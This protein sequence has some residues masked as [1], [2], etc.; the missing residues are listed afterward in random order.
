MFIGFFLASTALVSS[1]LGGRSRSVFAVLAVPVLVL[2]IPIFDTTFVTLARKLAGR[3]ASQGGRDHTSH[4]L[5]AL[6]LSERHAVWMLYAFASMAGLLAILAVRQ[7]PADMSVA[8][9]A[10]FAITLALVGVYL[11]GVRVYAEE[12]IAAAKQK[13]MVSFL[14]DM[15]HKRRVF[16]VA[17]DVMLIV[18]AYYGAHV[19]ILGPI[20]NSAHWQVFLKTLPA[21]VFVQL[22]AFLMTGI[23]RG[24]WRYA[25]VGDVGVYARAVIFAVVAAILTVVFVFRIGTFSRGVFLVDA[26]VL[27]TLVTTSRFAFRLMR[28][29]VPAPHIRTGRRALIFGAGDGGELLHRELLNNPARNYVPV[30]FADDDQRK[31]GKLMHGLRV[32]GGSLADVCTA[33][34]VEAVLISTTKIQPVRLRQ[35]ANECAALGISV[36]RMNISLQPLNDRELGWVFSSGVDEP[37]QEISARTSVTGPSAGA[38]IQAPSRALDQ[39]H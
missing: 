32:E 28:K 36:S 18:L 38:F 26:I 31:A 20:S 34:R 11:G 37:A 7:M 24:L 13:P 2:F 23:Y 25:S 27:M 9:I 10:V 8:A 19:L 15:T 17:L 16:E 14:M 29:L 12:E 39:G 1:Q 33:L 5:V 6:G 35:I 4:R 30:G 21:V 22:A 3:S